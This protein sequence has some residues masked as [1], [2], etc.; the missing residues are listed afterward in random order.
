MRKPLPVSPVSAYSRS[1][2]SRAWPKSA[3]LTCSA[4]SKNTLLGLRSRCTTLG[5]CSWRYCIACAM[6]TAHA[7]LSWMQGRGVDVAGPRGCRVLLGPWSKSL[8][9]VWRSSVTTHAR[10]GG[11]W[12]APISWS[13]KPWRC[14][15]R[16][17]SSWAKKAAP[18]GLESENSGGHALHRHVG[19]PP[20]VAL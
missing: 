2:R 10:S 15:E 6:S 8:R 11:W 9:V 20:R 19:A 13:T 1:L 3:T 4:S 17:W 16:V 18:L 14:R 7:S 5:L 12:H